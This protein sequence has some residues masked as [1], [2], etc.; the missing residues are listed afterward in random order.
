[1]GLRSRLTAIVLLLSTGLAFGERPDESALLILWGKHR[2]EPENHLAIAQDAQSFIQTNAQSPLAAVARGLAVWHLLKAG[3][4]EEATRILTEM[5]AGGAH[6]TIAAGQ[7]MAFRWLSR[8][9]QEAVKTG[10][11]KLYATNIEYPDSLSAL[12]SLPK[13]QRPPLSDRWSAPWAYKVGGFK[14]IDAGEKQTFELSCTKLGAK[15]DLKKTLDV[16]YGGGLGLKPDKLMPGPGGKTILK[17]SGANG[18]NAIVAEGTTGELSFPYQGESIVI[19]SNGDY[20]FIEP[21]P[22]G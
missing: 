12:T 1:M 8:L 18:L 20:W 11:R 10:L 15:S 19:L 6:P 7:E 5:T 22:G 16:V 9:D 4:N 13:E 14:H 21:K 17:I 3:N 2:Q